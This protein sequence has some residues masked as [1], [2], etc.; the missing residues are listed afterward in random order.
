[1]RDDEHGCTHA[2][3]ASALDQMTL[4]TLGTAQVEQEPAPYH[5]AHVLYTDADVPDQKFH[6]SVIKRDYTAV[7]SYLLTEPVH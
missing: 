5:H 7:W 4:T 1:M 2:Q 6:G 3:Q